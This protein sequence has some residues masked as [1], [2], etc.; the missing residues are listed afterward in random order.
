M[1]SRT[2]AIFAAVVIIVVAGI[3]LIPQSYD[4]ICRDNSGNFITMEDSCES[5]VDCQGWVDS[6]CGPENSCGETKIEC[7]NN[8]CITTTTLL[9]SLGAKCV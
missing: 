8:R 2:L 9:G 4:L 5:S 1:K 3:L 6:N 7:R